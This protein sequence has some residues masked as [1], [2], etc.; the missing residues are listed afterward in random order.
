MVKS[1]SW[2]NKYCRCVIDTAIDQIEKNPSISITLL[3][4]PAYVYLRLKIFQKGSPSNLNMREEY[5]PYLSWRAD[6]SESA[7][8][9]AHNSA[10]AK[11][12][13]MQ[14]AR[15]GAIY[16][17]C[18]KLTGRGTMQQTRTF[19]L[20]TGQATMN[21]AWN[22]ISEKRRIPNVQSL[23]HAVQISLHTGC[24]SEWLFHTWLE[25]TIKDVRDM[26]TMK[27]S[28]RFHGSRTK[29]LFRSS[30]PCQSLLQKCSET[31]Y[32]LPRSLQTRKRENGLKVDNITFRISWPHGCN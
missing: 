14:A 28:S 15:G 19:S 27:R 22:E 8:A 11:L 30:S 17:K 9:N 12:L 26:P 7:N 1:L 18:T 32:L 3:T 25:T 4:R 10:A 23:V 29:S 5:H 2:S 31:Q 21:L 16:S 6:V 24:H 13:Y 20:W